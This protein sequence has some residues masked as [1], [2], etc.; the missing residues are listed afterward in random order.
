MW[1]KKI[2]AI[3]F[4]KMLIKY[5][6]QHIKLNGIPTTI[7]RITVNRKFW[8]IFSNKCWIFNLYPGYSG[9]FGSVIHL[10]FCNNI[11]I[12]AK[13]CFQKLKCPQVFFTV[14]MIW[15][16]VEFIDN[17]DEMQS[18]I[19]GTDTPTSDLTKSDLDEGLRIAIK[20]GKD[21]KIAFSEK[22]FVLS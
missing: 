4:R 7:I 15:F 21:V 8:K 11:I 22:K 20:Y 17:M 3:Y 1:S 12:A 19:N 13:S 18:F 9:K 16:F 5:Y 2:I 6:C 10:R 14:K